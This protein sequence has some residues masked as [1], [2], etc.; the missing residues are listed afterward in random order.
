MKYLL[1][2]LLGFTLTGRLMDI[3]AWDSTAAKYMPLQVG[4]QWV[5]MGSAHAYI[6]NGRSYTVYKITGTADTLGH[7]YYRIETR[8]YMISGTIS[9]GV[10]QFS[11]MVRIDSLS[12]NFKKLWFYC[13]VNETSIDSLSSKKTDSLK[14]CPQQ[15]YTSSSYC[16]DTSAYSIFGVS[17]PS[18]T[19][20]EFFG[21]GYSTIYVK[22]IG[23]VFSSYG[24]QMNQS[25]DTLIGCVINGVVIGDTSI[26]VGLQQINSEIPERLVLSQN[27]P[28]P[29]NP[30]TKIKFQIPLLRG[31]NAEGGRGVFT[32]LTIYDALGKEA[33]VLLN[34]Q[35]QP[36]TYEADWD[37]SNYPSGIYYYQ[38]S[39]HSGKLE[40][41]NYTETKKMILIK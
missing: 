16:Y 36:G 12:M 21:P 33:A 30:V 18:K 17:Y 4:N 24:Y 11:N 20:H 35:L 1:Y 6:Q 27:Y 8:V 13:N 34:Q 38:I 3:Y 15:F 39:I 14:I 23:I 41:E 5:Y 10:M 26:L 32:N 22:G 7:H 37:A 19:F 25:T 31:L 29:F 2:I 40:T 28:N 9:S